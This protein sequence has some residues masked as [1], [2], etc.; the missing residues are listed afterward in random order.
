M[1]DK[2]AQE[3]WSTKHINE[4]TLTH[5]TKKKLHHQRSD[6]QYLHSSFVQM[7]EMECMISYN[8]GARMCIPILCRCVRHFSLCMQAVIKKNQV[9]KLVKRFHVNNK[10]SESI[11]ARI[12][13]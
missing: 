9:Y 11:F 5:T 8:W 10:Q 12:Q 4:Q 3:W 13:F 2:T 1:G 7:N 6:P